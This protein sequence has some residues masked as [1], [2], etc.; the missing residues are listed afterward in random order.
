MGQ[1]I[2][3]IEISK[4]VANGWNPNHIKP[5]LREKLKRNMEKSGQVLPIVVRAHSGRRGKYEIID[6]Y[7]RSEIAKELGWETLDCVI[8]D[9]G[10]DQ[11]KILTVNLNYMRGN[12]KPKEYAKLVHSLNESFTLEQLSQTLPE[13]ELQLQDS[14]DLLKLP[15][16]LEKEVEE[17]AAKEA[18]EKLTTLTIHATDEEKSAIEEALKLSEKKKKGAALAELVRLGASALKDK[19]PENESPAEAL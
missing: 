8:V 3:Q 1:E 9:A 5:A 7:H 13:N 11:A 19:K 14:L 6:G 2:K 12:A 18:E 17:R 10:D 15:D 16:E 4:L